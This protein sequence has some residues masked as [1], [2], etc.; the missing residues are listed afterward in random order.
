[1]GKFESIG[2]LTKVLNV[3]KRIGTYVDFKWDCEVTQRPFL[4]L[5]QLS[6]KSGEIFH[7]LFYLVILEASNR[8]VSKVEALAMVAP[9]QSYAENI[10]SRTQVFKDFAVKTYEHFICKFI[11]NSCYVHNLLL[12]SIKFFELKQLTNLG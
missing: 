9:T 8:D 11:F 4:V 5:F 12:D 2:K 3:S 6:S 1:M 7:K 10:A